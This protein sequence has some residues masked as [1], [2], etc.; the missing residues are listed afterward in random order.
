MKMGEKIK[1]V[2]VEPPGQLG[3]VPI[4]SAYLVAYAC[5]DPA[6]SE[7]FAFTLNLRHFHDPFEDV[8]GEI[9]AGGPPDIAAFSCQGWS[10]RRAN[11]L[12][13][14][15]RQMNPKITIVYGGNHVSHQG[16]S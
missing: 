12:A 1:V 9:I 14:K 6:I 13:Q 10:V 5:Q 15:L 8:V 16:D 7:S 4:A 11:L 3:Y 2:L